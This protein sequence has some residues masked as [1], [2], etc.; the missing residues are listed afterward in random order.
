MS[1]SVRGGPPG[2]SREKLLGIRVELEF[3]WLP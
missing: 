1:I 3:T 2:P